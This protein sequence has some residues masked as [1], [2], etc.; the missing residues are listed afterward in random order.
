[1]KLI[2]LLDGLSCELILTDGLQRW[3]L[4]TLLSDRGVSDEA[5]YRLRC[6]GDGRLVIVRN[7]DG[8][9]QAAFWQPAE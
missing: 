2:D 6:R 3:N 9:W 7:K 1:M 8:Q 4:D 5:D